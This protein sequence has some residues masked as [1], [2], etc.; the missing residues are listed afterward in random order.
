METSE[1]TKLVLDKGPREWYN[2]FLTKGI[3]LEQALGIELNKHIRIDLLESTKGIPMAHRCSIC[4]RVS[5]KR[6]TI[7]D[8]QLYRGKF[9]KD[10]RDNT[11]EICDEC[12]EA[13]NET[14]YEDDGDVTIS[15]FANY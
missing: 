1:P 4:D 11:K 15:P 2:K 13:I 3:L 10:G 9:H 14:L 5:D 12:V 7:H 8:E 6:I